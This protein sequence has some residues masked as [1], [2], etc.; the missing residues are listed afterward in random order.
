MNTPQVQY[1]L[2]CQI[3]SWPVKGC[4]H[5]NHSVNSAM[6]SILVSS[7]SVFRSVR[8]IQLGLCELVGARLTLS[9]VVPSETQRATLRH[10]FLQVGIPSCHPLKIVKAQR[11]HCLWKRK[12]AFAVYYRWKCIHEKKHRCQTFPPVLR[13]DEALC[14]YT[15]LASPLPCRLP[16]NMTS[17][18]K[19][20]VHNVLHCCQW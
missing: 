11:G 8:Q 14:V 7:F 2:T 19:P 17:S 13:S 20:E 4:G 15:L 1:S 3:S 5:G 6:V 12:D 9:Y 18:T 16:S 10:R